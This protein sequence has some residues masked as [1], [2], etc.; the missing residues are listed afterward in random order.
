MSE[1]KDYSAYFEMVSSILGSAIS[2]APHLVLSDFFVSSHGEYPALGRSIVELK[3]SPSHERL[4]YLIL[5]NSYSPIRLIQYGYGEKCSH[6]IYWDKNHD[7]RIEFDDNGNCFLSKD[8]YRTLSGMFNINESLDT[9][10]FRHIGSS[11]KSD[12]NKP[13]QEVQYNSTVVPFTRRKP[14]IISTQRSAPQMLR[15]AAS[16][17][18]VSTTD[19]LQKYP[20]WDI[21]FGD[22]TIGFHTDGQ[23]IHVSGLPEG[24]VS[25]LKVCGHDYPL[26][27]VPE[28]NMHRVPGLSRPDLSKMIKAL[29]DDE[30]AFDV[31]GIT[32]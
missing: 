19:G 8:D 17:T 31:K 30:T 3:W 13:L 28:L 25:E 6:P 27:W 9:E 18:Q 24:E 23:Y 5:D 29:P 2:R 7:N 22:W 1:S 21:S 32:E 4:L 14:K 12:I 15:L 16:T 20:G 10:D 26:E 11:G